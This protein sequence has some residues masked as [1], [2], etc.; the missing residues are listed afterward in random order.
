MAPLGH[1]LLSKVNEQVSEA[2]E[3]LMLDQLGSLVKRGLLVWH[4]TQPIIV[5][6]RKPDG[7]IDLVVKVGGYFEL[8]DEEYISKLRA[9]NERMRA[10]FAAIKAVELP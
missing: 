4:S 6:D 3:K 10:V 2:T 5:T 1:D 7:A 8:K 9:E